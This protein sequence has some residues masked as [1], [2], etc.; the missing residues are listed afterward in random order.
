MVAGQVIQPL[1]PTGSQKAP[2]ELAI[3]GRMLSSCAGARRGGREIQHHASGSLFI[4][5]TV[6]AA[7]GDKAEQSAG[8]PD[9]AQADLG[10]VAESD[11]HD[12]ERIGDREP[13]SVRAPCKASTAGVLEQPARLGSLRGVCSHVD[14]RKLV[15]T[16][17]PN[18][19]PSGLNAAPVNSHR[20]TVPGVQL[21]S[22]RSST[23][24]RRSA[25]GPPAIRR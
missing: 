22:H 20:S 15:L 12:A 16:T 23:I 8:A 7:V 4:A 24:S 25:G 5:G 19:V 10:T 17:E 13:A 1:L 11:Q 6:A 18:R 9:L 21:E 2:Q 14:H 3:A